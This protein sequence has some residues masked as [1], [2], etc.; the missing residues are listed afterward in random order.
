MGKR[1]GDSVDSN[2][3]SLCSDIIRLHRKGQQA[4]DGI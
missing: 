4:C 2:K 3:F 1:R